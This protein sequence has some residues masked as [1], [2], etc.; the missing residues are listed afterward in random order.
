M[1]PPEV[2]EVIMRTK[3]SK[4]DEINSTGTVNNN[5]IVNDTVNIYSKEI[6]YLLIAILALKMFEIVIF[7]YFKHRRH[8]KKVYESRNND[9]SVT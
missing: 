7:I 3:N 5:V 4:T 2:I 1:I 9:K 6:V 8:L